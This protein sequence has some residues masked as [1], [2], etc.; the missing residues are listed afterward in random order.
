MS[1]SADGE[2]RA[3]TDM[4]MCLTALIHREREGEGMRGEQKEKDADAL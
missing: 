4:L 1:A 3:M 2:A